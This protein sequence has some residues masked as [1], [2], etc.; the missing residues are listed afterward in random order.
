MSVFATVGSALAASD[1]NTESRSRY[2]SRTP[3]AHASSPASAYRARECLSWS[4]SSWENC[5]TVR[6]LSIAISQ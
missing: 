6:P 5:R 4:V 2:M 1:G 3:S